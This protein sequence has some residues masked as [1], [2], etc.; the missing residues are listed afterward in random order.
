[1]ALRIDEDIRLKEKA[2]TRRQ[3]INQLVRVLVLPAEKLVLLRKLVP[4][5]MSRMPN[6]HWSNWI[7][8]PTWPPPATPAGF[9]LRVPPTVWPSSILAQAPPRLAPA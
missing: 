3:R 5:N 2:F 1:A 7:S 4:S 8:Q 6:T 9:A